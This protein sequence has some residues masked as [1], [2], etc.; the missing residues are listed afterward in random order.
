MVLLQIVLQTCIW[1]INFYQVDPSLSPSL[2]AEVLKVSVLITLVEIPP[3]FWAME[4]EESQCGLQDLQDSSL[5]AWILLR[6]WIVWKRRKA[7][8]I[9]VHPSI[10]A[11]YSSSHWWRIRRRKQKHSEKKS[12]IIFWDI[13]WDT[14]SWGPAISL[15]SRKKEKVKFFA[16]SHS[17]IAIQF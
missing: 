17:L 1:I 10:L 16:V 15:L 3:E 13:C 2:E 6:Y 5:G 12:L 14:Y 8:Q 11:T 9:I 4:N 7:S